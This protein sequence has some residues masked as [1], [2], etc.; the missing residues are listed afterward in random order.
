MMRIILLGLPG[1][2]KGTQAEFIAK[3]LGIFKISTGDTLRASIKARTPLGLAVKKAMKKG[4]LVSDKIMIALIKE[5]INLPDCRE[6]YLLDGFPRNTEQ[7]EA[8]R[9]QEI[10]IDLVVDIDVPEEEVIERMTGRLIHLASGRIYHRQY[11]PPKTPDKDDITGEP[12]IQRTD[13]H[14]GTVRKRL[15]VYKQQTGPLSQYYSTWQKSGDSQAPCYY[16]VSGL[17]TIEEVQEQILK[18]LGCC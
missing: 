13:D 2:G 4:E 1:A 6:G 7:A 15:A 8:L 3:K 18:V 16:R 11:N 17:G 14:E 9:T 10:K 5:C 12:L